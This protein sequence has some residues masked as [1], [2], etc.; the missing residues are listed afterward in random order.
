MLKKAGM[1]VLGAAATMMSL[2]PAAFAGDAQPSDR[3]GGDYSQHN[4]NWGD[5]DGDYGHH[6]GHHDGHHHGGHDR[7][8]HGRC[9]DKLAF[10]G[11]G[12]LVDLSNL[13]SN[14]DLSHVNVLSEDHSAD[15]DCG[16][17]DGDGRGGDKAAISG[18]NSLVDASNLLANADVSHVNVLSRDGGIF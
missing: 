13:A 4:D 7:D 15:N 6:H 12:S 10:S 16:G 17:R 2:S 3:D 14:V 5:H 18:G 8:G 9:G 11:G 1:V